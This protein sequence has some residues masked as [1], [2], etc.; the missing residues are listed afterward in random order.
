MFLYLSQSLIEFVNIKN[1]GHVECFCLELWWR[2]S[3]PDGSETEEEL[4]EKSEMFDTRWRHPSGLTFLTKLPHH[5]LV[6]K[7]SSLYSWYPVLHIPPLGL[8]ILQFN[9]ALVPRLLTPLACHF[10]THVAEDLLVS[11]GIEVIE[12]GFLHQDAQES[13]NL[14]ISPVWISVSLIRGWILHIG[15]KCNPTYLASYWMMIHCQN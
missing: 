8:K 4:F 9:S 15:R 1:C 11:L 10:L 14:R 5:V 13:C 3:L 6:I 2:N 7:I 12:D